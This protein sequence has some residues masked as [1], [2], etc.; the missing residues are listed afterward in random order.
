MPS[1]EIDAC[2]LIRSDS[3]IADRQISVLARLRSADVR[4]RNVN[5]ANLT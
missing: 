4:V 5:Q 1:R 2:K 3:L